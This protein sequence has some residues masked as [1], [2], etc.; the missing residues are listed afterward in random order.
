MLIPDGMREAEGANNVRQGT[1]GRR[2][3]KPN[4]GYIEF[5]TTAHPPVNIAVPPVRR[6]Y[7]VYAPTYTF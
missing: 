4:H 6:I 5:G 2:K 3:C 1:A 7:F